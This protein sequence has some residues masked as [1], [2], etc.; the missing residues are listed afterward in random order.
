[1]LLTLPGLAIAAETEVASGGI[2]VADS[3][4]VGVGCAGERQPPSREITH[5][6]YLIIKIFESKY[7][8]KVFLA[9]F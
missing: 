6:C 5:E 1:L 9:E 2:V 3:A 4:A 7:C 8:S